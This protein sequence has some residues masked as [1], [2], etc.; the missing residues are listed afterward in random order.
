MTSP[1]GL[2]TW[3]LQADA[4]HL[5]A[6]ALQAADEVDVLVGRGVGVVAALDVEV[7]DEERGARVEPRGLAEH[8]RR[9]VV[10]EAVAEEA[11][12]QHLVVDVVVREAAGAAGEQALDARLHGR[13]ELVAV[14]ADVLDPLLHV[15]VDGPEDAVAPHGLAGAVAEVEQAVGVAVVELAALRLRPVPLELVLED[16]PVHVVGEEVH[17]GG[18]LDHLAVDAA[19]QREAVVQLHHAHGRPRRPAQPQLENHV[20]HAHLQPTAMSS[21]MFWPGI[22]RI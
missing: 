3:A 13:H 15:V 9:D 20:T 19:A 22:Y 1:T 17:E 21:I 16:G 14:A 11:P 5:R 18:V 10:P 8:E 6:A 4:A 12:V 7:V 2:V